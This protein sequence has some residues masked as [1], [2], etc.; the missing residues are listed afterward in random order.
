M[1]DNN[2]KLE[3]FAVKETK[4]ERSVSSSIDSVHSENVKPSENNLLRHTFFAA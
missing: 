4:Q 1:K 2:W 3:D